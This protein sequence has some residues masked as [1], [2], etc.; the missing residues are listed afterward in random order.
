MSREALRS[1]SSS[2]RNRTNSSLG[3]SSRAARCGS[4]WPSVAQRRTSDARLTCLVVASRLRWIATVAEAVIFPSGARRSR[5]GVHRLFRPLSHGRFS[6]ASR[7][8]GRPSHGL[9]ILLGSCWPS[10]LAVRA[11]LRRR[12]PWRSAPLG[13]ART[14]CSPGALGCCKQRGDPCPGGFTSSLGAGGS[15][16]PRQTLARPLAT[17]LVRLGARCW[18]RRYCERSAGRTAVA[19][20]MP[21]PA[22]VV[23]LLTC[24]ILVAAP[25]R[26]GRVETAAYGRGGAGTLDG[27]PLFSRRGGPVPATVVRSSS[28]SNQ[29]RFS[30]DEDPRFVGRKGELRRP[31][32]PRLRPP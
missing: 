11:Q 8:C 26:T 31:R 4:S 27:H 14:G 10:Y 5:L 18:H 15:T 19:D 6:Q 29:R 9:P 28:Q 23:I 30:P 22:G 12:G 16:N 7:S 20:D 24:L 32:S 2:R 21:L 17:C 25:R 1:R 3:M 13:S